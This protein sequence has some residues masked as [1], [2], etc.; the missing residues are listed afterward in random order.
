MKFTRRARAPL[1][2]AT[3]L[4][5]APINLPAF[6]AEDAPPRPDNPPTLQHAADGRFLIGAAIAT[7]D[8]ED[9]KLTAL[10][11]QQFN[12][13]TPEYDFMPEKLID[14]KGKFTFENGDKIVAFAE[15]NQMPV[16]G[17]MLVWHF[18][19][20]KWL[21]EN[22]D[23]TTL[24]RAKALANLKMYIDG[25]VGHYRGRIRAWDVVNEAISDN[26]SEYL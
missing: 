17:H 9:P 24:P 1:A 18:V 21:F 3:L 19:T 23:G 15:K 25:V 13:I 11:T 4:A 7:V 16:F 20:R 6:A 10:V 2:L 22:E 12:C 5:S 8:L 26:E 14:D